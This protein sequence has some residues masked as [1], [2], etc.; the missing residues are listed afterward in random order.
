MCILESFIT[1][2][3]VNHEIYILSVQIKKP[4]QTQEKLK[5]ITAPPL[6]SATG[7]K[8]NLLV[9][10]SADRVMLSFSW[11]TKIGEL[12]LRAAFDHSLIHSS[13]RRLPFHIHCLQRSSITQQQSRAASPTPTGVPGLDGPM[14][15]GLPSLMRLFH[16]CPDEAHILPPRGS[17]DHFY[18]YFPFLDSSHFLCKAVS[19]QKEKAIFTQMLIT[20]FTAGKT[21]KKKG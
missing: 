15:I 18:S 10:S 2:H 20:L 21:C 6:P 17:S 14:S 9:T 11:K 12:L 5:N 13:P 19:Q 8:H 16:I 1:F 3:L 7:D 4:T